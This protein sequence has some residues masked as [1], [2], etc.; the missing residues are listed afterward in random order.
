MTL[1]AV[2]MRRPGRISVFSPFHETRA[3]ANF[4]YAQAKRRGM[5]P[6]LMSFEGRVIE[7]MEAAWLK[8]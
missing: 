7:E 6:V 5:A 8:S 3:E 1:Y 2:L 4:F